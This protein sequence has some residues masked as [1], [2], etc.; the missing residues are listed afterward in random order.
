MSEC[1]DV[2]SDVLAAEAAHSAS[3]EAREA[4][5]KPNQRQS[6]PT[7]GIESREEATPTITGRAPGN[8]AAKPDSRAK[9]SEK[10]PYA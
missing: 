8:A 9:T 3:S 2:W 4:G 10:S 1:D 5:T 7:P 6:V